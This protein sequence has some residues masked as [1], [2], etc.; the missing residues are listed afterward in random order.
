[1]VYASGTRPSETI[2]GN[3]HLLF[4]VIM[5]RAM[6]DVRDCGHA[7]DRERDHIR[8]QSTRKTQQNQHGKIDKGNNPD[9]Y[10]PA[11]TKALAID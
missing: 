1:M 5:L 6:I 3:Y 4:F 9:D 8:F 7:D 2:M 11:A 10:S